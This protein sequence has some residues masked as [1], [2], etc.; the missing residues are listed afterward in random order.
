MAPMKALVQEKYNDW[1]ERLGKKLGLKCQELTGD[2]GTH[3]FQTVEYHRCLF[4][5]L[6]I[7]KIMMPEQISVS[8]RCL[9]STR[10]AG[11]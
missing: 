5:L 9:G 10:D 1:G 6:G 8:C 4:F 3:I 11:R 7:H 2:K